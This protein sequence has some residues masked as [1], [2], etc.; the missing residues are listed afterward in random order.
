MEGS[1]QFSGLNL[2]STTPFFLILL[3]T[4]ILAA[5]LA[6]ISG[7]CA[8]LAR[9]SGLRHGRA[10]KSYMIALLAV[11][12]TACSLAPFRWPADLPLV[13]VGGGAVLAAGYGFWFRWKRRAGDVPHI[14]A[15]GSSFVLMLTAFYVDNGPHL[16]LW[17]LLPSWSFWLIPAAVG[18]PFIVR[19]SIKYQRRPNRQDS[20]PGA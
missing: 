16:P 3:A 2:A 10:G 9:K 18:A 1:V 20:E 11:F 19:A 15:M 4:H 8:M 7:L 5:L 12:L 17:Q 6:I 13:M 14:V